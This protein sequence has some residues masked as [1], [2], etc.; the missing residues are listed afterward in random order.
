MKKARFVQIKN[1]LIN[2]ILPPVCPVCN[3]P[4]DEPHMLC[5]KCFA[6]LNFITKPYCEKCGYPFEFDIKGD[7]ICGHCLKQNPPYH[8]ARSVFVYDEGSKKLIL[9]F[10]HADRTD[11]T[12]V[13]SQ[14]LLRSYGPFISESDVIIPI[15]LHMTRLLMRRYNQAAL[16]ANRLAHIT[17]KR[18][19]PNV[20]KRKRATSS[21]G[22]LSFAQRQKNVRNA[23]T[24]VRPELIRDQKVLLIDDVMTT[25]ATVSECT[26]VLLN[27]GAKSV[28]VLTLCRVKH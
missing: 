10:K 3:N 25:G 14:F 28:D 5:A 6:K 22:H 19:L 13:L 23:F 27:A 1:L 15:P 26:K 17:H 7:M 21:Q 24:V 8:K 16:L 4:V 18:Y 2:F 12:H 20:L 9:P 11:L